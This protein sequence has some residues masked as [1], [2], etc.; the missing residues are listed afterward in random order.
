M[1]RSAFVTTLGALPDWPVIERISREVGL[2]PK[3]DARLG[4]HRRSN[5][6]IQI[7]LA[8]SG[9]ANGMAVGV[10]QAVIMD[11][12][13]H[14]SLRYLARGQWE[15]IYFNLVGARSQITAL[16]AER[17]HVVPFPH[18]HPLIRRWLA[19]LDRDPDAHLTLS[20]SESHRLACEVLTLLTEG[21]GVS[22]G[23]VERA[24][25]LMAQGWNR[26]LGLSDVARAVG[27]RPEHLSRLFHRETGETP[28]AW[29]RRHRL[30]RAK[31]LLQQADSSVQE[32]AAACG[33]QTSTHFIASFRAAFA[34]TPA[35]WR[36]ALALSAGSASE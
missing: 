20:F 13:A 12:V 4:L 11:G 5:A 24:L 6:T 30:E 26:N 35:R 10:G 28:A 9:E 21:S 15:F 18:R 34:T 19:R 2:E 16:V 25:T 17:G 32:V 3:Y 23:I 27:V 14:P 1:I 22:D 7:T 8:G 29:Y 33:F 31:D 36:Q